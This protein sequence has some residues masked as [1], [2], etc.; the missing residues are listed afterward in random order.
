M[1]HIK[2]GKVF[3]DNNNHNLIINFD[4]KF[5]YEQV[6]QDKNKKIIDSIL[7]NYIDKP[8]FSIEFIKD[9]ENNEIKTLVE[10]E[11]DQENLKRQK[12]LKVALENPLVI[13]IL[14]VFK[15]SKVNIEI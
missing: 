12:L 3:L 6:N 13:D 10:I 1:A 15:D 2:Q 9:F 4:I 14:D 7:S 11:K 5:H 8:S